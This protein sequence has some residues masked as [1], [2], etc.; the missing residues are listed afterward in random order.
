MFKRLFFVLFAV[1]SLNFVFSQPRFT[2]VL[3]L[4]SA[5]GDIIFSPDMQYLVTS[6]WR[7]YVYKFNNGKP[8]LLKILQDNR[9]VVTSAV[10]THDGK[11]FLMADMDSIIYFYRADQGFKLYKRFSGK[12]PG[13]SCMAISNDDKFLVVGYRNGMVQVFKFNDGNL[14]HLTDLKGH[15]DLVSDLAFSPDSRWLAT[16]GYDYVVN[17]YSID[18]GKFVF[19]KSLQDHQG[20]IEEISFSP[21]SK[22]LVTGG[23]DKTIFVYRLS[24][25]DWQLFKSFDLPELVNSVSFSN[26]GQWLAV[27]GQWQKINLYQI[28]QGNILPR[29]AVDFN[30]YVIDLGFSPKNNWLVATGGKNQVVVY[31]YQGTNFSVSDVINDYKDLISSVRFSPDGL[32]LAASRQGFVYNLVNIYKFLDGKIKISQSLADHTDFIQTIDFSPDGQFF[33]SA[34]LDSKLNVYQFKNSRFD[35]VKT[36]ETAGWGFNQIKFTSKR[37]YA[38][39]MDDTIQIYSVSNGL[40]LLKQ[41][42]SQLPYLNS[43]DISRDGKFLVTGNQNQI[44]LFAVDGTTLRFLTKLSLDAGFIEAVAFSPRQNLIAFG[45]SQG[46]V[47]IAQYEGE[48]IRLVQKITGFYDA[49]TDVRFSKDGKFLAVAS[50]DFTVKVFEQKD[51]KFQQIANLTGHVAEVYGVD[52]TPDDHYLVTGGN[53]GLIVY[54]M[55][56][57]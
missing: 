17:V 42:K 33:A 16:S 49:I 50:K 4:R 27:G 8:R 6:A 43:L 2:R 45:G 55:N 30:D 32:W 40:K 38:A 53:D 36:F 26:D 21:D 57:R 31:K 3:D 18:H 28:R 25:G 51:S 10:F 54:R 52:F 12:Y 48:R 46:H 34:G 22:W 11:W 14:Q 5:T 13:I 7:I 39:T 29:A 1:L 56:F 9:N 44:G 23:D 24:N 20:D 35:L 15:F 37:L 19:L 41:V 47:Y